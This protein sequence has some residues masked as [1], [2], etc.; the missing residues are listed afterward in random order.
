M[1][2]WNNKEDKSD[3]FSRKIVINGKKKEKTPYANHLLGPS[4]EYVLLSFYF[5][6]GRFTSWINIFYDYNKCRVCFFLI[7]FET[8]SPDQLLCCAL[9]TFLRHMWLKSIR[10]LSFLWH[11][12]CQ[13]FSVTHCSPVNTWNPA[14]I[15]LH[16]HLH[17]M[18]ALFWVVSSCVS[19]LMK[20]HW[21]MCLHSAHCVFMTHHL[22]HVLCWVVR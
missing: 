6:S 4:N 12:G 13:L 18:F 10:L 16:K 21:K 8:N 11:S 1:H 3:V 19:T 20:F 14:G 7:C 17:V 22:H 9:I 5:G 2:L 15:E